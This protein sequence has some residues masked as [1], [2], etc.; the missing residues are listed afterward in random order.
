MHKVSLITKIFIAAVVMT[1]IAMLV[2]GLHHWKYSRPVELL[3]LLGMAVIASRLKVKLPGINGTMSVN[4]PYLLIIA[5]RLGAGEALAIAALAGLV[6]SISALKKRE[7][8]VQALFSSA[9]ITNSIA[10]A[11]LAFRFASCHGWLGPLSVSAAGA[12]F[13]LVN[14]IQIA[15]VLWLA[16]GKNLVEAWRGMAQL[17]VPYYVLSA[18][19]AAVVCMAVQFATWGEG[20]ALLPIMYSIH[21]SYKLYFTTPAMADRLPGEANPMAQPATSTSSASVAIH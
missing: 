2:N 6:Q 18:E 5:V 14:T 4:V 12:A 20:L 19:I 13:F 9:A 1:G 16:E 7:T 17:S 11:I 21:A 8:F 3:G 15:L 10:A